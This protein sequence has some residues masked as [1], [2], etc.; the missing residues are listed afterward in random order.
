MFIDLHA[1]I[2]TENNLGF[3]NEKI[4]HADAERLLVLRTRQSDDAE[5]GPTVEMDR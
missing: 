3:L 1:T 4:S 5:A 2:S